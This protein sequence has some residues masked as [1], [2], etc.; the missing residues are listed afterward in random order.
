MDPSF[1]E[2]RIDVKARYQYKISLK[3]IMNKL[4]GHEKTSYTCS[5]KYPRHIKF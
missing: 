5:K 3:G 4:A 1:C 2:Q